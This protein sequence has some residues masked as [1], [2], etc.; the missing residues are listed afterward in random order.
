MKIGI[1]SDTHNYL[2]PKVAGHFEGVDLIIHAGDIG[3]PA[4]L[5]KLEKLAPIKA[6]RGN[7]DYRGTVSALPE[8]IAT[9]RENVNFLIIHDIG[10]INSFR[11]RLNRGDFS[12]LPQ[13]IIFGHT[14]QAFYKEIDGFLFVNPGS[15]STSRD[16]RKPSVMI[17][18]LNDSHIESYRLLEL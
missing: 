11:E 6:I 10:N 1:I 9:N 14:H 13:V 15:A 3:S 12:P 2:N 7:T 8:I 5:E 17:M 16:H 4:I 18:E